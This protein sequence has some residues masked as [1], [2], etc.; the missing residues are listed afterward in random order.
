LPKYRYTTHDGEKTSRA[1]ESLE[2]PDD[3]SAADEAQRGLADIAK[4]KLPDGSQT[5]FR[6]TVE[7]ENEDVIY[8]ASLKFK[9]ET[10]EDK[11]RARNKKDGGSNT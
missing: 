2:F 3:K 5:E 10:A 7:D 9:G 8:Q 6:I 1:D 4:E 11:R